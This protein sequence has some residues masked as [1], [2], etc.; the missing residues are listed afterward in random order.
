MV[1]VNRFSCFCTKFYNYTEHLS[2]WTGFTRSVGNIIGGA[3]GR[4]AQ[5]SL[6]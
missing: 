4:I 1:K 2:D 3:P 6:D 5:C